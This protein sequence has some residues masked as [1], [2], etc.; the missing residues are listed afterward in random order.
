MVAEAEENNL[1]AKVLNERLQRWATC[2]LC[3]QRYHGVVACALGWACWKTYVGRPEADRFRRLAM[4]VLLGGLCEA[5]EYEDALS[6]GEAQLSTLRRVGE[7]GENILVAQGN[8]AVL[9]QNFGRNEEAL[10]LRRD[11]YYGYFRLYGQDR[12]ALRAA[13]CYASSL[14]D[15][16]RFNRTGGAEG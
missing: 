12:R 1:G 6:V 16:Q 11:V 5:E 3:E 4:H 8:L 2:S 7:I 13:T 15:L 14:I 9:Y 10:H